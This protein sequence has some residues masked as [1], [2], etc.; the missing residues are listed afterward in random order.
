MWR[1]RWTQLRQ[2]LAQI[3]LRR[4]KIKELS[5]GMALAEGHDLYRELF[6]NG[7]GLI[8]IHDFEG[9]LEEINPAA[10]HLLGY[11]PGE[12]VGHSLAEVLSPAGRSEMGA[13]LARLHQEDRVSGLMR[14]VSK[15]GDEQIWMYR[16]VRI[17]RPGR[18][19]AVLGYGIDVTERRRAEK[20]LER[21]E[22]QY[23]ELFEMSGELI[24]SVNTEGRFEYVNPHWLTTLG[25]SEDE[26]LGHSFM[27]FLLPSE[28]PHCMDVF[29]ELRQ[30]KAIPQIETV[31]V[32]KDGRHVFVEG[33][34]VASFKDGQFLATRG[35]FRDVTERKRL[36]ADR[37]LHLDR[38]ERQNV[39]LE[40]RNREIEKADRLKSAFL[41]AMSHELRTP[42]TSIM[43]FS[44]LLA[45]DSDM[46]AQQQLYLGYIRQGSRHL[47]QLINDVLDFSKIEA[48][49]LD[50]TVVEVDLEHIAAESVSTI[51]PLAVQREI[52]LES[53]VPTGLA[54]RA[55]RLRL[56]QVLLNLLGNA[57]KFTP[58]GGVVRLS[59]SMQDG[60]VC[61]AVRDTG[62]GIPPEEQEMIFAGFHQVGYSTR[63]IR[64][65]AGLG[66]AI[67]RRLIEQQGGKIWVESEPGQGSCFTFRLPASHRVPIAC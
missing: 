21:S 52:H 30:G 61:V 42:L 58:A 27:E 66:L 28:L 51:D 56:K 44:D 54:V 14:V 2:F 32:A 33:S 47:L 55:D 29:A 3:F 8:C 63:G 6:E 46:T 10:A 57:V 23:R 16:N 24:Q 41:D 9:R 25:Y 22:R 7:Q 37:Q 19:P 34:S 11:E 38:I 39:D 36:E 65:G 48:G 53:D 20:A 18:P 15:Q 1:V 17:D 62:V 49:N 59:A 43:G 60:A 50:L 45:E 40:L 5:A 31:F 35:F 4:P 26:I 64:E 67:V 12:L 13:Y